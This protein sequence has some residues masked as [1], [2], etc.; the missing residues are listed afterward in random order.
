MRSSGTKDCYV[1]TNELDYMEEYGARV[2]S[3][4]AAYTSAD[5]DVGLPLYA[6]WAQSQPAWLKQA[7]LTTYGILATRP[8]RTRFVHARGRGEAVQAPLGAYLIDGFA[9]AIREFSSNGVANV[10]QRG[11]IEAYVRRLSLELTRELDENG[12]EVV[13]IYGDGVFVRTRPGQQLALPAPWRE[14]R[15]V[16]NLRYEAATRLRSDELTRLPGTPR[17]FRDYMLQKG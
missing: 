9:G 13:S 3:I 8:R 5:K 7:L 16:H 14:K 2:L 15:E 1:W 10:I 11:L 4:T 17:F 6:E 12:G